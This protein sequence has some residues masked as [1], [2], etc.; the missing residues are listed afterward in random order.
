MSDTTI[1]V[2][3]ALDD[4]PR[5]IVRD[6]ERSSDPKRDDRTSIMALLIEIHGRR[7]NHTVW[8][9]HDQLVAEYVM[10]WADQLS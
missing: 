4:L 2:R 6:T 1:A 8:S 9:P 7:T 3:K 5:H 10:L